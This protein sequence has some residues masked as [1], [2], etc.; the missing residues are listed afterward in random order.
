MNYQLLDFVEH[1]GSATSAEVAG[2][3]LIYFAQQAGVSVAHAFM[4]TGLENFR[5]TNLP[6]WAIEVDCNMPGLLTAHNVIA[7]RSGL[8]RVFWG[9]ELD[10]VN[11]AT[12]EASRRI[13]RHRQEHFG[14]RSSVSFAMPD[15]D[16]QYRGGGVGFGFEDRA[17]AFL[18]R[19]NEGCGTLA[20]ASFAAHSRMQVLHHRQQVTSPLSKRQGEILQLLAAGYQLGGISDKLDIA[21]STVNL[22]LAQ[23]KKKLKVKTKEQALAMAL[24]N[25]WI[26]V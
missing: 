18:K 25:G 8:P 13:A 4:G 15:A 7:V 26:E 5:A 24:T 10:R 1:I 21:D 14:Q 12:T 2:Q 19:M 9:E 20:L 22:H 16:G 17:E 6:A 3:G 23:L 11:P